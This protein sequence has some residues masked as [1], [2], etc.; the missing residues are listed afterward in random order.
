MIKTKLPVNIYTMI[1]NIETEYTNTF[2]FEKR[3]QQFEKFISSLENKKKYSKVI[4]LYIN[5]CLYFKKSFIDDFIDKNFVD[6]IFDIEST[7]LWD[8]IKNY[9]V[10]EW[11]RAH[12][13][14]T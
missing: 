8:K 9:K 11:K 4:I 13:K 1:K 6:F 14:H 5:L 2:V 3:V 12:K 10:K 7:F